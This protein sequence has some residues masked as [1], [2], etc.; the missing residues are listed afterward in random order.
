[1]MWTLND[2]D[3][4]IKNAKSL[5]SNIVT[6]EGL[7]DGDEGGWHVRLYAIEKPIDKQ[8]E[9]HLLGFIGHGKG[10]FHDFARS[11]TGETPPYPEGLLA[12]EIGQEIADMLGV[13]LYFPSPE[14][15]S[16]RCE[17]PEWIDWNAGRK[18]SI[19]IHLIDGQ[20]Y[21][22]ILARFKSA[23]VAVVE[24]HWGYYCKPHPRLAIIT[25]EHQNKN[26]LEYIAHDIG[27]LYWDEYDMGRNIYGYRIPSVTPVEEAI[28]LGIPLPKHLIQHSILLHII[29]H[30]GSYL[31]GLTLKKTIMK[32]RSVYNCCSV[33]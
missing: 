22:A 8:Y 13:P 12:K 11:F 25:I 21:D 29:N 26:P 23:N 1:M 31:V 6:I 2:R 14:K 17:T 27:K 20:D 4:M 10:E 15:P 28:Q 24:G 30:V 18:S 19:P 7:W 3:E 9:Y 33:F 16:S 32:V 5:P